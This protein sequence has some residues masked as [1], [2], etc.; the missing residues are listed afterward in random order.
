MV[1]TEKEKNQKPQR[2]QLLMLH[3]SQQAEQQGRNFMYILFEGREKST[4]THKT[5]S[6]EWKNEN[7][8]G[9]GNRAHTIKW[10]KR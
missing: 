5:L 1:R 6:N 7:C 9:I 2:S 8:V 3:N 10:K 4:H